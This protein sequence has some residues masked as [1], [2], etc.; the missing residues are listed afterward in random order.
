[1][2]LLTIISNIIG[3]IAFVI[4]ATIEVYL[5]CTRLSS[6]FRKPQA[7]K[8]QPI[9]S[10]TYYAAVGDKVWYAHIPG[11]AYEVGSPEYNAQLIGALRALSERLEAEGKLI[12]A[13]TT[14]DIVRQINEEH[15]QQ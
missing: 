2:D 1:M 5:L 8:P 15:G 12:P 13:Q 4:F 9:P 10:K 6:I 7:R 11:T 3:W 14:A